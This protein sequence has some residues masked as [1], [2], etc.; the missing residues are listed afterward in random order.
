MF[1]RG[2]HELIEIFVRA[3]VVIGLDPNESDEI[4]E[5]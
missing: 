5:R 1:S 2:L 3:W 4:G